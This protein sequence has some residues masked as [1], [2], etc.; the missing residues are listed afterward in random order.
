MILCAQLL[1]RKRK[2]IF[3]TC[4]QR[5]KREK[6]FFSRGLLPVK[7]R[8]QPVLS[9]KMTEWNTRHYYLF[10]LT[11]NKYFTEV[12]VRYCSSIQFRGVL[13]NENGLLSYHV[14]FVF[15]WY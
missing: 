6:L 10:L 11:L 14:H 4:F 2:Y 8:I 15:L 13:W 3:V 5:L 12:L 9:L 1:S 7:Y